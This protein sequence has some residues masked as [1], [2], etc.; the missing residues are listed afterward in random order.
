VHITDPD[1]Y[2]CALATDL[3]DEV[4]T[5]IVRLAETKRRPP[6]SKAQ[7]LDVA[8]D[9]VAQLGLDLQDESCP[10]EVQSL[11]RTL[12]RW[13]AHITA[14]HEAKVTAY[15]TSSAGSSSRVSFCGFAIA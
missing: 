4:L 5:T 11:G 12:R 13:L 14:W 1:T 7:L 9:C 15:L 3:P 2:L 6:I 10:G 8:R